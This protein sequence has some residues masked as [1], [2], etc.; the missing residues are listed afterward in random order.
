VGVDTFYIS[1][2]SC[3][4]RCDASEIYRDVWQN[5]HLEGV[6]TEDEALVL[7]QERKL[8]TP[9]MSS[10]FDLLKEKIEDMK[11]GLLDT[12]SRS[13]AQLAIRHALK[14]GKQE[15]ERLLNIRHCIDHLTCEGLASA[16]RARYLTGYSLLLPDGQ[17]YWE[18]SSDWDRPDV[19]VDDVI[20]YLVRNRLGEAQLREIARKDPWHSMWASRKFVGKG[21]FDVPAVD[22]T[23][24][25]RYVMM[26]SSIYDSVRESS[27]APN[28]SVLEDD[29]MLDGW[30]LKQKRAREAHIASSAADKIGNEKIKNADEVYVPAETAE[31]AMKVSKLNDM[32]AN[33]IKAQRLAHLKKV[34]VAHEMEM[35]DTWQRFQMEVAKQQSEAIRQR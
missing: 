1:S 15:L 20:E 8:W 16:A 32:Q 24:D 33:T 14:I 22:L 21:L 26:W 2:P 5:A 29:D 9:E 17:P 12:W 35:P 31:D 27:D 13:N 34:G 28:D 18:G 30:L 19:V 25:Q 3:E 4:T 10:E 23:D 6:L 7:L 11:I